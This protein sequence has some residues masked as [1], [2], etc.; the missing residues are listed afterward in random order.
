[1]IIIIMNINNW[2]AV[3]NNLQMLLCPDLHVVMMFNANYGFVTVSRSACRGPFRTDILYVA[4]TRSPLE[5]SRLFG[6][7]PWKV[8]VATYEQMGS[9]ATQP[10]AKIF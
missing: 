4:Y 5:D 1:M 8:L 9:W 3:R 2:P 6:P 7:S 10:L